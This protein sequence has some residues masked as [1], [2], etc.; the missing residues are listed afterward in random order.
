MEINL[1]KMLPMLEDEQ[2]NELV[3]RV[4]NSE[5]KEYKGVSLNNILPFLSDEKV[6]EILYLLITKKES[7]RTLLPFVSE[8]TLHDVVEKALNDELE[9]D[10]D[11]FYPFLSDEDIQLIFKKAI[12]E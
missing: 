2:L 6:D 3:D 11:V 4:L 8:E 7:V 1:K 5:T 12:S 10:L 9:I